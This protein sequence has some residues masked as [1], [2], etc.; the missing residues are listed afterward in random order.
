MIDNTLLLK[1]I[2]DR[3]RVHGENLFDLHLLVQGFSENSDS[4]QMLDLLE[5]KLGEVFASSL[6]L[7][8][9]INEFIEG[10]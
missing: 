4:A 1:N 7:T 6:G 5:G 3:L 2:T 9:S 8:L 10:K